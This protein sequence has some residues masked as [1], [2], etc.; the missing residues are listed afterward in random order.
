MRNDER[1]RTVA[2]LCREQGRRSCPGLG[3]RSSLEPS[4]RNDGLEGARRASVK[5]VSAIRS[6]R[7]LRL[8]L[9]VLDDDVGEL[10]R[11]DTLGAVELTLDVVGETPV[12][13]R[14]FERVVDEFGGV[15][16]A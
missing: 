4:T 2:R 7:R 15:V 11:A 1:R 8:L 3:E 9:D 16:P 6:P 13:D 10:A 5:T 14:L 12:E